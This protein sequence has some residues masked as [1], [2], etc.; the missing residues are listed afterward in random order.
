MLPEVWH[1]LKVLAGARLV[2]QLHFPTPVRWL[3]RIPRM[4]LGLIFL[5]YVVVVTDLGWS[6][7]PLGFIAYVCFYLL[8]EHLISM[9]EL[10]EEGGNDDIG[11]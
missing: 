3:A 7:V 9:V 4:L 1:L 11:I 2:S 6:L 8:E 10:P 5:A